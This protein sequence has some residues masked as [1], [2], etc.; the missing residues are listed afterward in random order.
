MTFEAG[1]SGN[2]NGRPKGSGSRQQVFQALV[3]PH[4]EALF[5]KALEMALAGNEPMLRL[6]LERM[7]PAKPSDE[8]VVLEMPSMTDF[9]D[10]QAINQL[11]LQ[12]L[13]AVMQGRITPDEARKVSALMEMHYK[14][15]A[16]VEMMAELQEL[17]NRSASP[18]VAD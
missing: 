14:F 13:Y 2:P 9:N 4:K 3:M 18:S 5:S 8:P 17:K 10:I 11:G 12:S 15:F 6:L 16:L 1:I 7:L